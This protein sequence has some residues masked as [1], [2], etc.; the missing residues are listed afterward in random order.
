MCFCCAN[1]IFY[2]VLVCFQDSYDS[3]NYG[4]YKLTDI[5]NQNR[6]SSNCNIL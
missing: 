2:F 1:D 5:T 6:A 4:Y 3:Y